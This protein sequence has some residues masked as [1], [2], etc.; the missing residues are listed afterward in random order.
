M[1]VL[2]KKNNQLIIIFFVGRD[3]DKRILDSIINGDET[4][5]FNKATPD[6]CLT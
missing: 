5:I 1:I 2:L 3:V 4:N 6:F